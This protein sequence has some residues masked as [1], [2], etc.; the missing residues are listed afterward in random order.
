MTASTLARPRSDAAAPA[1][2]PRR[3]L[4]PRRPIPF[5]AAIGPTLLLAV[6][7]AGSATGWIDPRTL[8]APWTV[9]TTAGDLIADG[10]LQAN[11]AIS[12]QRAGLGLAIGTAVGTVL[13]V[14]AGLSRWGEAILDG[15][16]QIK[17]AIRPSR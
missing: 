13:A 9:V 3:R 5:G 10:R 15:P 4:T 11:L 16:V 7:A 6:W 1:G 14:L 17:R 12:A 2:R 8:S